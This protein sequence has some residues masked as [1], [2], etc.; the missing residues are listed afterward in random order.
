MLGEARP[1]FGIGFKRDLGLG[2]K[3]KGAARGGDNRGDVLAAE[4][5]RRAAAKE[6][7][8]GA[9]FSA[10]MAARKGAGSAPRAR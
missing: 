3:V 6:Q 5:R 1:I 9:A 7:R 2:R 10:M 8:G 4:E